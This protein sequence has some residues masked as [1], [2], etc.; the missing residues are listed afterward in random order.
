MQTTLVVAVVFAIVLFIIGG[1]LVGQ[2]IKSTA[3]FIAGIPLI[4]LGFL[5]L[6]GGVFFALRNRSDEQWLEWLSQ[7][8]GLFTHPVTG[9]ECAQGDVECVR[10]A[11]PN[12]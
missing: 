10:A 12:V 6:G 5:V 2:V 7:K 3:Q 4:V 11:S 8:T 9:K 1:L